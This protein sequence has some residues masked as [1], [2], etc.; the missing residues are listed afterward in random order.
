MFTD[1]HDNS[2]VVHAPFALLPRRYPRT[3]FDAAKGLATP[4]N[5]LVDAL[6]RQPD[7]MLEVLQKCV[8]TLAVPVT[9]F[10]HHHHPHPFP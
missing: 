7:W 6:A 5:E 4:F 8:S 3:L 9:A 2:T 1:V 10:P